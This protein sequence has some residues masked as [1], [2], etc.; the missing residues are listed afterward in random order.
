MFVD[1][2]TALHAARGSLVAHQAAGDPVTG[3]WREAAL[4]DPVLVCSTTRAPSYWL[5][6]VVVGGGVVGALRVDEQARVAAIERFARPQATVTGLDA[7][8][9]RARVREHLGSVRGAVMGDPVFV[10]EGPPGREAWMVE[11]HVPGKPQRRLFVTAA[12]VYEG[13]A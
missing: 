1:A 13:P 3:E 8:E 6:P 10:H 9:V 5:V 11:V 7:T 4:S 12:G 2:S